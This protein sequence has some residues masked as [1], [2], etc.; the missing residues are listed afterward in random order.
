[1]KKII[2]LLCLLV[3]AGLVYGFYRCQ[4][5]S[6]WDGRSQ[7][8]LVVQSSPVAVVSFQPQQS[9]LNVF[10]IPS[11]T[12]LEIAYGYGLY[13]VESI[14]PLGEL[15]GRGGE[16]LQA[17]VQESLKL[18]LDGY[19][20]L[21]KFD[22]SSSPQE[23]KKSFLAR[24]WQKESM[25]NLSRW[26]RLR[27]WWQ[28]RQIKPQDIKVIESATVTLPVDERLFKEGLTVAILN[29][30]D[31]PGLAAQ[32][33]E[34]ITNAGGQVVETADWFSSDSK[35]SCEIRGNQASLATYTAQKLARIFACQLDGG[36]LA[37]HRAD[38]VMILGEE[39]GEKLY[40]SK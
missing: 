40:G 31:R 22:W 9:I 2:V 25:T 8:N 14:Y 5:D 18:S 33:A 28:L 21:E 1:M 38:L 13:L 23:L 12:Y 35:E 19:L 24:L 6:F 17:S 4:K 15:D 32:A 3:G 20:F 37:G 39:Y 27:F 34:I 10:L 36:D 29:A 16:L 26:D 11:E 30:T 7:F